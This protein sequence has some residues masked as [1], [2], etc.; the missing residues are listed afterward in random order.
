MFYILNSEVVS[1]ALRSEVDEQMNGNLIWP[2]DLFSTLVAQSSTL[3]QH[4]FAPVATSDLSVCI[5][6]LSLSLSLSLYHTHP[7]AYV[8]LIYTLYIIGAAP[9]YNTVLTLDGGPE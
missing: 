2:E 9:L 5:T 8:L 7:V 4:N 1:L 3:Q 6:V